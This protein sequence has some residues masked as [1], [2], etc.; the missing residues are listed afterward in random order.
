MKKEARLQKKGL[1]MKLL[2]TSALVEIDRGGNREKIRKL[3]EE[4]RHAISQ[5]SVTEMFQGVEYQYQKNTEEYRQA[6]EQVEKLLSRFKVLKIDRAVSLKTAKIRSEL[7]EKGKTVNDLHD[8]YIAATA[9]QNGLTLLTKNSKH[10]KPV[11]GLELVK[12]SDI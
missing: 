4:G 1:K 9:I 12:W 7:R 5:V 10:F 8:T 3:D 2:D 11:K 6:M